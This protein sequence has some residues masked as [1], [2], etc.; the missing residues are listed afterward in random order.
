MPLSQRFPFIPRLLVAVMSTLLVSV[1]GA[2]FATAQSSEPVSAGPLTAPAATDGASTGDPVEVRGAGFAPGTSVDITIES[3]PIHIATVRAD[4]TGAF[5]T[6]ITIPAGLPAGSHTLKATGPDPAGGM[7][8][9]SMRV[10]IHTRSA[11]S[12]GSGGGSLPLTGSDVL[13]VALVGVGA[14]AVGGATLLLRRRHA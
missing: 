6:M 11:G 8:V 5:I 12:V 9:L 4:A 7:R 3:D 13:P 14:V 10:T 2:T 1:V